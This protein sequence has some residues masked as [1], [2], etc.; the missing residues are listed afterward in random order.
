MTPIRWSRTGAIPPPPARD[1]PRLRIPT[2]TLPQPSPLLP[3]MM[4]P[5]LR[6]LDQSARPLITM[7]LDTRHPRDQSRQRRLKIARYAAEL[8]VAK[9][10]QVPGKWEYR[11]SP[12]RDD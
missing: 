4:M 1:S 8:S 10:E 12:A 6:A 11:T 7:R 3:F 2:F 9:R 5:S